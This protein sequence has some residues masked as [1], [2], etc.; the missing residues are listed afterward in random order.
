MPVYTFLMKT[1]NEEGIYQLVLNASEQDLGN[2]NEISLISKII[3]FL[4]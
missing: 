1:N 4:I 2:M 3:S